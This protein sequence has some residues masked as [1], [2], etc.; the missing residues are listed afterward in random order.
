MFIHHKYK[1]ENTKIENGYREKLEWYTE[2]KWKIL[3]LSFYHTHPV[4]INHF[5][6]CVQDIWNA[7]VKGQ[8]TEMHR[9]PG[10]R[11]WNP[12]SH[13][14]T[15]LLIPMYYITMVQ[16][17]RPRHNNWVSNSNC[18]FH[19]VSSVYMIENASCILHFEI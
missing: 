7:Q 3:L 11:S 19:Q 10:D 2:I 14:D 4:H 1:C 16:P 15:D 17:Y 12:G 9:L 18:S 13:R 6:V 5:G 8:V